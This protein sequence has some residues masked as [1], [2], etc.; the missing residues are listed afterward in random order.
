MP[1]SRCL[2]LIQTDQAPIHQGTRQ[3]VPSRVREGHWGSHT[4]HSRKDSLV[5]VNRTTNAR[6]QTQRDK[7]TN[8]APS[9]AF[10]ITAKASAAKKTQ[11]N[12]KN[13]N[14]WPCRCHRQSEMDVLG[15]SQGEPIRLI[16]RALASRLGARRVAVCPRGKRRMSDLGTKKQHEPGMLSTAAC[17]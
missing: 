8:R 10:L 11:T 4:F 17:R 2:G 9:V 3:S 12:P 5:M 1:S 7:Q 14:P 13:T 15:R 6:I 16:P